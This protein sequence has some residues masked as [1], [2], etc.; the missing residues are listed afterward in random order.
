MFI[1]TYGLQSL[2]KSCFLIAGMVTDPGK[3]YKQFEVRVTE[4]AY[5]I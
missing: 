2:Q 4:L 3:S 5:S 1:L